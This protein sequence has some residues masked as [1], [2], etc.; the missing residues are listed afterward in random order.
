LNGQRHTE[1]QPIARITINI[2]L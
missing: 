2:A 1:K